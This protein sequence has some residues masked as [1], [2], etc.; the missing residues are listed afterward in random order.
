MT[1]RIAQAVVAH[2]EG[3]RI[4]RYLVDRDLDDVR[5]AIRDVGAAR[6]HR[7]GADGSAGVRARR[8]AVKG[9]APNPRLIMFRA[10]RVTT[11]DLFM[12]QAKIDE[13]REMADVYPLLYILE[14]SIRSVLKRVMDATFDSDWWNS[15]MVGGKLNNLRDKVA[16]RRKTEST[17]SWH[18]RRGAHDIDYTDF[19]DLL[20]IAQSK[21]SVFFPV[22]LGDADWFRQ[23]FREIVPSRNVVCHMNPLSS[24]NV[25]DVR[26]KLSRWEEHLKNRASELAAAMTVRATATPNAG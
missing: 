9:G 6:Q 11:S 22:L 2:D 17:N 21:P 23:F 26:L 24:T 10:A 15:E 13:A 3:I 4:E 19:D 7:G 1:V 25:G 16:A 20:T 14:N 12:P 5:Q 8:G 18:Q